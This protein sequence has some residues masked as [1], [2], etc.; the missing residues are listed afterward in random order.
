VNNLNHVV[1][2]IGYGTTEDGTKYWL[3]KN[4]WGESGYMR[5]QREVDTPE[6]L[7]GFAKEASY[8]VIA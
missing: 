6:G 5:I 2:A 4:S 1:T 7:C 3:V 8:P